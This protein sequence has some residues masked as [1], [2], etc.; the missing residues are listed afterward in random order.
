MKQF[1]ISQRGSSCPASPIRKLVPYAEQAKKAGVKVY[2]LNIG[3]P[4]IESPAKYLLGLKT[5]PE[6]IVAYENSLGNLKLRQALTKYYQ[7]LGIKAGVEEIIITSGGSEAI[8][9]SFLAV[10]D[11]GDNCLVT[12]PFYANYAGFAAM[13]GIKLKPVTTKAETGFH[14]PRAKEIEKVIDQQTRAII[15]CNPNNPTG[16]VY[17]KEE[18]MMIAKLAEKHKLFILADETYRE[19]V[20]GKANH[21]SCL[22]LGNRPQ[23]VILVDSFSKRYSLCG[24]RLGCLVSFNKKVLEGVTKFCQARLAASTT[25]QYAAIKILS[26]SNAYLNKAIQKY[27]ERRN[28]MIKALQQIPGVMVKTPEGAFYAMVKLPVKNTEDFCRWLLTDFRYQKAT[29]ML[30]PAAGFYLS[31]NL[32]KDEVRVAYVINRHDL[33]QAMVILKKSLEKYKKK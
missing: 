1:N 5:F 26:N 33:K 24:A 17:S 7:K 12:E 16:T 9:F 29:V 22:K 30:A 10:M 4:D 21:L 18:L 23:N 6:K 27:Q 14:L 11:P 3:Q 8:L 13:A 28:A 32:G 31:K 25:S 19:F 15:I 20:Y 2:H